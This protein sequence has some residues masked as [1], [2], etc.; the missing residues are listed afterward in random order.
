[1]TVASVLPLP[2]RS[3]TTASTGPGGSTTA[4]AQRC[5]AE[6]SVTPGN[7]WRRP[8]NGAAFARAAAARAADAR[9]IVCV[10]R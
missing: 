2:A 9:G 6:G 8:S 10:Q 1:M 7:R 5:V 4:S 3:S